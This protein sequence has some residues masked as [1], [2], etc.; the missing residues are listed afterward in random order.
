MCITVKVR[1]LDINI[2][3]M[4]DESLN[5]VS[6]LQDLLVKIDDMKICSAYQRDAKLQNIKSSVLFEDNIDVTRYNN[7]PILLS[8]NKICRYYR[9]AKKFTENRKLI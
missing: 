9:T 2:F 6:Q 7:C 1:S 8:D 4:I 3:G 5:D